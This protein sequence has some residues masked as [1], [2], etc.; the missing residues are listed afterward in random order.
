MRVPCK[1]YMTTTSVIAYLWFL[2]FINLLPIFFF[3]KATLYLFSSLI[4]PKVEPL[5][6]LG[7]IKWL[8]KSAWFWCKMAVG[9]SFLS[10]G[11]RNRTASFFLQ[12]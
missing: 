10:T 1:R 7:M 9:S 12:E 4:W 11:F 3:L 5:D 6:S 8:I 2:N